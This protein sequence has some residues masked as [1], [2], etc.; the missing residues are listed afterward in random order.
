MNKAVSIVLIVLVVL[1]AVGTA[2]AV[3]VPLATRA[4]LAYGNRALMHPYML[5]G[6]GLAGTL[7]TFLFLLLI[8]LA[9]VSLVQPAGRGAAKGAL[10]SSSETSMEILKRRYAQGEI[11]KEQYEDMKREIS[12]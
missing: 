1:L 3:I 4:P 8:V 5:G 10:P 9:V 12:S 2:A 7:V 6:F 11:T